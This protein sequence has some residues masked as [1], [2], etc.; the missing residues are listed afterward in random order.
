MESI[1]YER[2]N[3]PGQYAVRYLC[4]YGQIHI[5]PVRYGKEWLRTLVIC[6]LHFSLFVRYDCHRALVIPTNC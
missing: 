1:N 4:M 6:R 2:A 3:E 5:S